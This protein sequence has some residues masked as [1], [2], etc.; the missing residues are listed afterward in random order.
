MHTMWGYM[1]LGYIYIS[2]VTMILKFVWVVL[3]IK[4]LSWAFVQLR[5]EQGGT[6]FFCVKLVWIC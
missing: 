4:K 3:V 6:V 2:M 5:Y 1:Q